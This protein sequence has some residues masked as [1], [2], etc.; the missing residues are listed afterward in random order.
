ME[1]IGENASEICQGVGINNFFFV[2]D[3]KSTRNRMKNKQRL[4]R[5]HHGKGNNQQSEEIIYTTKKKAFPVF[6]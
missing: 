2:H 1:V 5:F 3:F 4:K 6:I